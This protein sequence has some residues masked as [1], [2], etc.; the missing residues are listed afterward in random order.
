MSE[1]SAPAWQFHIAGAHYQGRQV[2]QSVSLSLR[3]GER[4][5]LLGRSGAG[6]STL[7]K[8]L[9]QQCRDH[10]DEPAWIPQTLGL[11]ANLSVFHNV[12]SGRLDR[13]AWPANLLNLAWPQAR[14]KRAIHALLEELELADALFSATG[15][16]SGG[17]QQR[18]AIARALYRGGERLLAD[19]PLAGL[20][21]PLAA[22]VMTL[23]GTRF[24]SWVMALHDPAIA[25]QYAS[26]VI[27]LRDGA[28]ALDCPAAELESAE[29]AGLY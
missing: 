27:G 14:A 15:S 23:I 22:R 8:L 1:L 2:L 3:P 16:L 13:H 26:R 20:D 7:L 4:I 12:Y 9:H 6:K 28:I 29:L 10:S 17:Q 19:E 24:S 18:V 5:T 11:V 21:P 25:R